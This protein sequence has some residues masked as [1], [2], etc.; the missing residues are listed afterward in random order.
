MNISSV[1]PVVVAFSDLPAQQTRAQ[2]ADRERLVQA[3]KAVNDSNALG[4]N[5]ELT[6]VLDRTT[7]RTLTRIIDRETQEVVMQIPPEYV[8]QLAEQLQQKSSSL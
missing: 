7:H 8:V 6:F 5:H 4:E 3:V 2:A 1:N